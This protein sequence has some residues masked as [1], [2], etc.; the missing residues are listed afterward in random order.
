[1][2]DFG[3]GDEQLFSCLIVQNLQAVQ[4][5]GRLM[6]WTL[7]DNMVNGLFFCVKP[8]GRRGGHTSFV[9]VEAETSDT[10]VEAVEPDPDC[11]WEGNSGRVG[12]GV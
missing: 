12:T 4:S 5:M 8:T 11:S 1:M 9:Q 6:D 3:A 2:L 7:E 10:G